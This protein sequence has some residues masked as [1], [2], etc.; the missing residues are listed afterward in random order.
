MRTSSARRAGITLLEVVIS[1]AIF[2]FSFVAIAELLSLASNRAIE[3]QY[4]QQAIFLCQSKLAEFAAGV[5]PMES[6]SDVPFD[7]DADWHWSADCSADVANGLWSVKVTVS[8]PEGSGKGV[9]VTVTR[10]LLDPNIRGNTMDAPTIAGQNASS[11]SG[12][13]TTTPTTSG[14]GTSGGM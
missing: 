1:L 7:E 9:E 6:Q 2:L 3:A 5:Q 13:T 8:R 11:S 10:M 14:T 4:R 12:T